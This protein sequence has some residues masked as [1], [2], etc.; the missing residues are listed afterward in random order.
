MEDDIDKQECRGDG[1]V[2]QRKKRR[3]SIAREEKYGLAAIS[4][5]AAEEGRG[6]L[7]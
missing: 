3:Q 6:R 2:Q 5:V 4:G 1:G 7:K